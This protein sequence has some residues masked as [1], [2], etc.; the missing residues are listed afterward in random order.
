M[1]LIKLTNPFLQPCPRHAKLSVYAFQMLMFMHQ[2]TSINSFLGRIA[3]LGGAR[4]PHLPEVRCSCCA[5]ATLH[6]I[7]KI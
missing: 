6:F 5:P 2:G 3:M 1:G 7:P 4:N